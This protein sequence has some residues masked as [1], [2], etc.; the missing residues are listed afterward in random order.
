MRHEVRRAGW[1]VAVLATIAVL[2]P[3]VLCAQDLTLKNVTSMNGTE[4]PGAQY[5]SPTAT[6][7]S[8]GPD[9]EVILRLDQK[10]LYLVNTKQKT[11]NEMT[12]DEMQK[13]AAA[14]TSGMENLPPEAAAQMKKMMGMGGGVD[15]TVT[16]AGPGETIAG[17]PTEKYHV[18]MGTMME[19]DIWAAPSL[20]FP[21]VYYDAMKTAVPSNPMFDMKKLY[22]EFKKMKGVPLKQVTTTKVMGRSGTQT[23]VV[24][25]V[26]KSPIP[27]SV[28]EVPAGFKLVPMGK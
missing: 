16:P 10:K 3:T 24:T 4:T 13:L 14:T 6:K 20:A 25:S 17:Y 22:E 28:F 11:Y 7:S 19:M 15:V 21:P 12:F 2:A 18:T 5:I 9:T 1:I 27:A 23:M 26:D 8:A